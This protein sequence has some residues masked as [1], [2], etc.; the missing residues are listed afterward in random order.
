[1]EQEK[2]MA[3]VHSLK[4]LDEVTIISFI[5]NNNVIAEYQGKKYH[6]IYNIFS[7]FFYV[8]NIYGEVIGQE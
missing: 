7:G 5:D 8:D 1:M 2:V 3:M 6:A 4:A